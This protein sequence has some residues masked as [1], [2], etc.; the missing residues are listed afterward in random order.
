MM[1]TDSIS[2]PGD[3]GVSRRSVSPPECLASPRAT[4]GSPCFATT[5][6]RSD[7]AGE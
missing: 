7:D 2:G 5:A 4:F 3:P 6:A 1:L